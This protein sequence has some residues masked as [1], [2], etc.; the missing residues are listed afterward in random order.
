MKLRHYQSAS[1][2]AAKQ[3]LEDHKSALVVLPTGSGKAASIGTFIK[4]VVQEFD[5][6][7]ILSLVHS[8][9]LV[10]QNL[11][12]LIRIW[13]DAPVSVYSAGLRQKKLH[14]QVVCASI[15]SIWKQAY[16]LQ[17]VDL[18][19][20]DEAQLIPHRDT[21]MYRKLLSDLFIIN[22]DMKIVLWTATPF[23][24]DTGR[25]DEG[26]GALCDGV[27]YELG[28]QEAIDLGWLCPIIT[29]AS[30]ERVNVDGVKRSMGEFNQSA[31]AAAA[32]DHDLIMRHA[33]EMVSMAFDRK[34]WLVFEPGVQNA[35]AMSEALNA[36]GVVSRYVHS[37]MD[38]A[39]I[40]DVYKGY[41]EGHIHAVTNADML[42]VG[43][44]FPKTNF[45]GVRRPTDSA[46]L[47]IQ[48]CGRGTRVRYEDGFDP[49]LTADGADARKQSIAYGPKPNCLIGDF[50]GNA[51][52]HGP[53]DQITGKKY[54]GG[55]SGT[56]EAPQKEC[57]GCGESVFAG[58]RQCAYCGHEFPPNEI[59]L[60]EKASNAPILSSHIEPEW[61]KVSDVSYAVHRKQGKPDSLRITY[62]CGLAF[63]SDWQCFEHTGYARQKAEQW[64]KRMG[65]CNPIP[66]DVGQ[67]I[68]RKGELA[69]PSAILVRKEGKYTRVVSRRFDDDMKEE[70]A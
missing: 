44:D 59:Q 64:W 12:T 47:W 60:L 63:H 53:L 50:A 5:S 54:Y 20:I 3:Y 2:E 45:L 66:A 31:I 67:C 38:D 26:E 28:L 62:Q 27:A 15:Q 1:N 39:E 16:K 42:T 6:A 48:I 32:N 36:V 29:A 21:G 22:P 17:R 23:R 13:P 43:A 35:I 56:G 68:A 25:L 33:E 34:H 57:P 37:D 24:T 9:K 30:K 46:G 11:A 40:E 55:T 10:K 58:V 65:G 19:C 7:R 49:G 70:A 8:K 14:G 4:E 51:A 69:K 41:E 18:I 52:R 61:I